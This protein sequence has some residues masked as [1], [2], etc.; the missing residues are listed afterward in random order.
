MVIYSAVTILKSKSK[1]A[2]FFQNRPKS[3]SLPLLSQRCVGHVRCLVKET[4]HEAVLYIMAAREVNNNKYNMLSNTGLLLVFASKFTHI[5]NTIVVHFD[6]LLTMRWLRY[7]AVVVTLGDWFQ[8]EYSLLN[9]ENRIESKSRFFIQNR[10]EIDR[11][12]EISYRHSTSNLTLFMTN[13]QAVL[14]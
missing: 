14:D 8:T 3:K 5:N 11:L 12:A 7:I 9:K 4:G 6:K 1:I 2:I 10:I 13:Y